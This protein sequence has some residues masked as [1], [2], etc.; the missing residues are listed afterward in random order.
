MKL[1]SLIAAVVLACTLGVAPSAAPTGAP[2]IAITINGVVLP[3]QPPP[4][5]VHDLLLVPVRRT[6]QALGLAF[7]HEGD[8]VI[9][10]V[11]SDNVSLTLGDRIAH[12]GNRTV[13]LETAPVEIKNV[14]YAPLRFF[15]DVLGAQAT[16][17]RRARTVTI[18][19][20]LVGRTTSGMVRDGS[21]VERFGTVTAVDVISSPP[22]I[23]L[24]DNATVRTISIGR[25]ATIDMHDVDANVTVPGELADI[26][27]GDF[28]RI[29]T[30][31]AGH[32]VRVEDAFGSR[33]GVVAAAA[34]DRF[35]MSDGHV[36]VPSRTTVIS[37][38]GAPAQIGD[39]RVGDRVTVRYNVET[40]EVRSILVSRAIAGSQPVE[41]GPRITRVEL[42]ADRPLK[43]GDTVTV[44][45]YGTPGGAATFD[46][47]P[48]VENVAM[49]G[50]ANGIYTGSYRLPRGANFTHVPIIGHL[51]VNG[52]DAADVQG[53]R[54]L[55]AASS[56]P[57]VAD[58][59]PRAGAVV[60]THEPAIYA[61]FVSDA[62]PVNPSSVRLEINGR[63]VTAACVRT[64]SY[65]QYIPS[66]AYRN[67]PMRVAVVVAD[68]AGN[69]TTRSWTF[70]IRAH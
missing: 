3:L 56:P 57:G 41:G 11:G 31:K 63:D 23:T 14:L 46:I 15:T 21:D 53:N 60:N 58:V 34:A 39:V 51:R 28:V 20:Q 61:T 27:P 1:P 42:D 6:I 47:G 9:T 43:A 5:V 49:S 70:T 69:T 4:L 29:F 52:A 35:V 37:I 44:T 54:E 33:N 64:A 16:Y 59:A 26:R 7:D 25:N 68:R 67:G 10:Q 17:D 45:L 48:Y 30:S 62:V 32:V 19:A 50:G 24:T 36:V 12:I 2:P 55:S 38:D 8:Q 22:T 13:V 66:F 65:I 18:V 40:N